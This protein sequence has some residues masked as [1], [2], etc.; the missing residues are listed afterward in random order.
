MLIQ[1]MKTQLV[2]S[3]KSLSSIVVIQFW[4]ASFSVSEEEPG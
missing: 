4:P 3:N 2:F 1:N